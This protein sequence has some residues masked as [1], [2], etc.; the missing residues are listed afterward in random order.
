MT[1]YFGA[2]SD[3]AAV[4]ALETTP[5]GDDVLTSVVRPDSDAFTALIGLITGADDDLPSGDFTVHTD[6][7]T[8]SSQSLVRLGSD[9]VAEIANRDA[10]QFAELAGPWERSGALQ[11]SGGWDGGWD[12]ADYLTDL[13]HLCRHAKAENVAVYAVESF[14]PSIP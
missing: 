11:D 2:A 9:L 8:D 14:C 13:Q 12:V 10:G 1:V 7:A 6:V 4:A 3:T 5:T